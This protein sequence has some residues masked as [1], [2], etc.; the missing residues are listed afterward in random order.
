MNFLCW[1]IRG[2]G[3]GEKIISIRKFIDTHKVSFMGLIETKHKKTI[4]SRTRRMWGNDH[5]E[6]CE[7]FASE[8]GGGGIAAIWDPSI[9]C[10]SKEHHRDRWILLEGCITNANFEC[11]IGIVYGPNNRGDRYA[12][13]EDLKN[14][15]LGI[16][17]PTLLLGD[18]N[19]ILHSWERMG[20]ARCDR[21]TREF[22]EWIRDLGLIDIPLQGLKFTWRRNESRSKLDRGLC[23]NN[24]ITKFP[25]LTMMGLRRSC[26]DHNPILLKLEDSSNWGPKPFRSYDAWFLHPKFRSFICNE[27]INIPQVPLNEKL[28]ILKGPLKAWS[29]QHFDQLDIRIRDLESAIH[30]LEQMSDQ[31]PLSD[32]EK[33]RLVAA[34]S[35]LQ[36][37]L[38]RRE[39]IWRQKART[40]GFK[41]K[42]HN[43]K[44]FHASTLFRRKKNEIL[45][46]KINGRCIQGISN[47]KAGI[48]H[49]FSQQ[50][51]QEELPSFDFDLE[52][53]T[54]IS[55]QQSILLESY[56]SR[57]EVKNAVWA[58]GVD[59]A[60]GYDGFNFK[61]LRQM[62]E[63]IKEEIYD[64][65]LSFFNNELSMSN[66]NIAW[67]TLIPK[68][69]NPTSID[70]YR[71]ISMVG[72]LYKI[73]SKLLS[74]RLKE[75][76][77]PLVDESQSAFLMKRQILDSVL[78]ANESLR[79][80]KKKKIPGTMIKLDFQKA[81]DSVNWAFL[82]LAMVKLGFGRKWIGWIMNC[83]TSA[84]MSI[85]LNGTPLKPFKMGK[86]LRQGD[87]LSPYLFILV[88]EMLVHFLKKAKDMNLIE[89][90][91]IG[92]N[93]VRLQHL[94][95][96][97][98]TLIFAP[99]NPVCI[100]NYFRILD[101]FAVMSGL[102]LN[103]SKS[104]F[105]SW[106]AGDHLW[107]KDIA[108][109]FGCL[110][111]K[112]PVKYLGLPLGNSM[113]R[114]SAWKPVVDKIQNRLNTWKARILSR[115]GRLTL[116]KSVLN[117]LPLYY[118]S[119]FKMPRSIAQKI[120][121]IQRNFF[122]GGG[123]GE[124]K[125]FP[126]V[127]WS[128]IELPKA[129]GGLGVGNIMHKN[130]ILLFKWWWRY[131][132]SNN[133]LWKR[134]LMSVYEIK[135]FKASA[136]SFRNVQKGPWA[137][138]MSNDVDTAK[139][140]SIVEEG[141]ILNVGDGRSILFWHDK[142]CEQGPL[143]LMFPRLYS[144]STQQ[145]MFINQA[146][147]WQEGSW[148]WNLAWRRAAYDWERE[149]IAM[150]RNL[151][152]QQQPKPETTDG[153]RWRASG[154]TSFHA[155]TISEKLYESSSPLMPKHIVNS[156]WKCPVPPRAQLTIWMAQLQKLKTGDFLMEKGIIS[157]QQ[158]LCPFCNHELES[159][160]HVMFSCTF[161]WNIWMDILQWWGI[162]GV[163][164]NN[165]GEFCTA[166]RGL[167]K[168]RSGKKIWNLTLGCTIWSIWYARNKIKFEMAPTDHQRL[169]YSIKI[170]IGIW[171][172][173]LLGYTGITPA[174]R[175][176]EFLLM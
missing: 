48:R 4:A 142:W 72:A 1:N 82:E 67:V 162:S 75:V 102:H 42:D 94:Q 98:D 176:K 99:K 33:A 132:E 92:K 155:I 64:F 112:C 156:I 40:Y 60:P 133:D 146:G 96:A 59:K 86:G 171:A 73:I 34:Q 139:T 12:V 163:L 11:C 57:E 148:V 93:K 18:F 131:S 168:E 56:P 77:S 28:K 159:N 8:E 16:N 114:A 85:L 76:M 108:R 61:F 84:S 121:K 13:F 23:C 150:L 170:R 157:P 83:V 20:V 164:H 109:S 27:W 130:L 144:L 45:K 172:K 152:N 128:S 117:S 127:K 175:S 149:E 55:D 135:R 3:K 167:L 120:V 129:L 24:W 134:I 125:G 115:A 126:M 161:S 36:S 138:M 39:R 122:W 37:Y 91:P 15:V 70:E 69:D 26:S 101:V 47:L 154:N 106:N 17:K 116:I 173:E 46:I 160:S 81:Y 74:I 63:T 66:I 50:F 140:R 119:M 25:K 141:M 153:V 54:R 30:Q 38:I 51:I 44:F 158:A 100:K 68:T 32:I 14:T 5:F 165:C 104:S 124:I 62:W 89:D 111:C 166:W 7:V 58:C 79:W 137:Q 22:S 90:V 80:L 21:S 151:I 78:I 19:V 31:R 52:Q 9:F 2:I 49:F 143:K 53:H 6:M 123:N 107:A 88:S 71:P 113:K 87:P 105:I 110:H 35:T 136:E 97:D 41:M 118:M 174:A 65:V 147:A 43:T 95:F 169:S 103:Y 29:K 145:N 10:I